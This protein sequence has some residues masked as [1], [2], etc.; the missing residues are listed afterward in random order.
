MTKY[1]TVWV[2]LFDKLNVYTNGT[3]TVAYRD[4]DV[5]VG[6]MFLHAEDI[7]LF[8][9]AQQASAQ[10]GWTIFFYPGWDRDNEDAVA[11]NILGTFISGVGQARQNPAYSTT[12]NFRPHTRLVLG[13]KNLAG[14][15]MES[16][17]ISAGLLIKTWGV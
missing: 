2:P 8:T 4:L 16:G 14:T 15:A 5:Q 6:S 13:T 9:Y 7:T 11:V 10:F 12:A 3:T 17:V 1:R